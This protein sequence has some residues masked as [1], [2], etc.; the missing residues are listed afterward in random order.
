VSKRCCR[1]ALLTDIAHCVVVASIVEATQLFAAIRL[2]GQHTQ[3][4]ITQM[5]ITRPQENAYLIS[6]A[7]AEM[8]QQPILF[9]RF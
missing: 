7:R 9:C 6:P 3:M 2:S 4:R 8:M 1:Q 5:R